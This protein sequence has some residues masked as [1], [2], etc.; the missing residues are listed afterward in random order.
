M[1][2]LLNNDVS[3]PQILVSALALRTGMLPV[4][5]PDMK[6]QEIPINLPLPCA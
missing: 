4:E 5:V 3:Q 2:V 1:Y 6:N